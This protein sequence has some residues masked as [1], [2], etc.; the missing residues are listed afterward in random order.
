MQ[1]FPANGMLSEEV[2]DELRYRRRLDVDFRAARSFG[3]TY[4][5][6]DGLDSLLTAVSSLFAVE[7]AFSASAMP[8]IATM[9]A[10]LVEMATGLLRGDAAVSGLVTS[11]GT[12]SIVLAVLDA[13]EHARR[14]GMDGGQVVGPETAHPAFEKASRLLNLDWRP[15]PVEGDLRISLKQF[16]RALTGDTV[17]AVGSAPA[18]PWGMVDDIPS[19]AAASSERGIPFHVDACIGGFLLPFLEQIGRAKRLWDFRVPGVTSV[20]ADLH[21]YGYGTRGAS[22]LL[23]RNILHE[24]FESPAW[25]GGHY[26]TR[27]ILGSRPAAPIAAAWS[28]IHFLGETG[29]RELARQALLATERIQERIRE[30][31]DLH[32]IGAP[33]CCVLALGSR[34]HNM[35]AVGNMLR[36]RGWHLNQQSRPAALHLMVT[37]AHLHVVDNFLE[38]LALVLGSASGGAAATAALYGDEAAEQL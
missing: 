19:M 20:S 34:Q 3:L 10:D 14:R 27:G 1:N 17:M 24:R 11:G 26:V 7:N 30:M 5:A 2:L 8:S 32:I 13:R 29:Y 9:Q 15:I 25:L 12:E 22:V 37:A 36:E 21:K 6:S 4:K 35:W 31:G 16:E 33:D 28:A 23:Y 38:D 18:Y